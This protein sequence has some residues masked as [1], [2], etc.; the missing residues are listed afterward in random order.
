MCSNHG[1]CMWHEWLRQDTTN[2]LI[3]QCNVDVAI[4]TPA[5]SPRVSDHKVF[6]TIVGAPTDSIDGM[7]QSLTTR[8]SIKN[9]R[10]VELEMWIICFNSDA[11]WSHGKS[12]LHPSNTVRWNCVPATDL[13]LSQGP[14]GGASI[15]RVSVWIRFIWL[16][17]V[18]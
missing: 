5:S 10:S 17:W 2:V 9:T 18:V 4:V 8:S 12:F 6:L 7:V 3:V 14:I 11:N 16:D 1:W 13:D 15:L